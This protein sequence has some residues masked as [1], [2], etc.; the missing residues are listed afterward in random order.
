MSSVECLREFVTERLTAAAEEIFRVVEKTIVEYEEEIARQRRL[1]DV[2]WK[3]E[4]KLHRIELPQQ[5]VCNE[6]EVLSDQQLCIQERNSSLDQEDPEPPQIKEEQ[7][8]LCPSQE[9][10]Q[11]VLKQETDTFMLTPTY[12]ESDHSEG[13]TLNFNPDDDSLSAAE[14]ESVA[15]M[16][17]ITSVVSEANSDHQLLSHNSHEAES[18]DQKGGKH[19]DSGSTRNAEPEPKKRRRKSRSHSNN[20]DNT[21][22]SEI[23]P[24]TQTELPQQHVCKEEVVLSDQQLCIQER[25]SSLDQEDPEP[26]QIKEEQEELCTSQEGEQLVL[27]QETD[28]FMLTPTYEESDHSE[29]QTLNFNPDDDSLSAAEKESVANMPVITSVV[30][31]A[32]SDHQL[33]SHNSH[34]AESQDQKGGKHG[35]SEST[36]NAEPEPKKRRRK[37]RS[38]SNNVDNTNVSEIHPNTQTELP[39][40]HVC[41]EEEVLSDQQLCIQEKNSSLDQEDPEPPQIKEEQEELCT[42]QEGE[43]LVL[44]Q[45]TDTFMLTP[46]YEESDHSEGQTLNFNPDDD[47]LSAAEKESVAN[48]PVITS[49]ESEASS[50]HQLLSHNSHEAESQDQKGDKHGDSGSTRNAEPEPKKR[51]QLPQQHVCKEEEVLS[52]QQLCIQERNSSLDQEDPEPPQIKEE[53][54]ELCPSQ[55]GEQL[56]LKQETDTFMLTPTYDDSLSAAEKESVANMPVITSVVSEANSD[57]QLLSHNSHEAESQDQKGGKHGDS[58]STRNAEPEPKKRR[59]KSRSHSNNVDN[60]NVSEIHPNTQTELPQQHVCKEEEV[61][62]DQQVCIQERNSSLDQEDPEPPQIK[63]EQEELCPSQEGEQLV[64]KQETDTFMLTPTY[65]ESVH[66]EGQTLDFNPDDDSLSAAENESVANM[67]VITSV[68][69]EA[70]SDH[71]LLS[72][73]SHEAESQDQKGGKHGDSGSTRN[74]EPEPKKRRRKSRS[75]RNN[76]DNTNVSEIHPNTQTEL[77]QQHVCKEEEVLSDQQLCIQ[78]RNSSLDQEDPEP[79]QVKEEQEELCPSQEEEQLVLKQETDTFMLTPTYEESD[80]SEGQTLNFNPD[81]DSLSAA[82]KESVANMPVITSVVSEANSDHQLLSHNSHEAESQDQKGDKHGNSVS[83]RNAEPEPKKRRRK[84]RSHCNNVDNTNVSEIHRTTQTELP[85]Q[86][87]CKEEEVLSDQQLCIQERNSSLDQEDPE[88]PQ[89]NEEQEELC[90]SQEGEQLVL[91]QE[92]DT[93]MLTPTYEESDH[94]EG[95]TLN[96]NPDDDSLSAAEKESV[97]N[98]PVITSVVSEA[99]SDHQL[100]SHNSHEAESQ[101]QKGDKHGDS[102]STRDSEPEPKKRRRKSRSHSNNVDNTNVSEIHPNTQTGKKSFICDT[103]GK[104]FKYN[105]ALQTHLI[106]HTELPQ[107]HVCKEEEVL[108]DQQL[109]MPVITSVVSEANS[110]HQLLS[111][112]S[113]EAESQDQKGGKHGDSGSTRNAEPEPKKRR[114]KSRSHSNNVDNT[115]VSEIHPNTQTDQKGGKHGDS[116]STRNAEPEP[117]KRQRKNRSNHLKNTTL[118]EIH[119]NTQTGDTCGKDV[120]YDSAFQ[121]HLRV[122]RSKK[123]YSCKS[124]GKDFVSKTQLKIHMKT[125]T[126]HKPYICKT[127]GKLLCSRSTLKRHMRIHTGEKPYSCKTCGKD[128]ERNEGLRDHMR[129]HTGEKPYLCK[130][131]GKDFRQNSALLVHMRIHTGDKPY[132]CKICEKGFFDVSSLKRHMRIHTGEK[133]YSCKTCGKDFRQSSALLVHVRTH[134]GEKPYVCKTCGKDFKQSYALLVHIR[135]HTGEK[136]YSCKR[137]GKDFGQNS[138]LLVHMRTHTGEKPFVCKICRESFCDASGLIKHMRTH[139]G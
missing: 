94:S 108:S 114:R 70:N 77:P 18:Q 76:V 5:H 67:P 55:E 74:A 66:S 75:H 19:G 107:Q 73:N 32:N 119:R 123:P 134:T 50:D 34:E 43:Q 58:G 93:F 99:N 17:V 92:T 110:D 136:P 122:H 10:E 96:F 53:Q 4:I 27:K 121:R 115:N 21:N 84:S 111:H 6:E 97:A 87:V 82:E 60:T 133:P 69:S 42:S 88:P 15:N 118:S 33:L 95:Q 68:V 29:G 12:E 25:N 2:V 44:K 20:V 105:S 45:E 132:I 129:T 65:E 61:L 13:Q 116:G 28:T 56:V 38:H 30:S 57:H 126:G 36:R 112:N 137:C 131:C 98:M 31:E 79:P 14:K 9:G 83:T 11:L 139:K 40:Q 85:Q 100:L 54:E 23:H 52:D 1:L 48:M 128:F 89:I 81:D 35:D 22:V 51:Q 41:K 102:G 80:H 46:T 71:Q 64:L 39:Q 127:C 120:K 130:T 59:R 135:T 138:G 90:T 106:V 37:S 124:C 26:P 101:D 16:P 49:V 109:N 104:D 3:P 8:E 86:H 7:E 47:S 117:K 113:H 91:K 62:S 103:C 78:E 24:N 72:H 125:Y 63:E